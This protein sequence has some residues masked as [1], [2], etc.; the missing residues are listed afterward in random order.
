MKR[1]T[2]LFLAMLSLSLYGAK[3]ET[4][5]AYRSFWP[6]SA[7]MRAFGEAGIDTYAVMPSNSF[8]TLGEPYCKFPPFWVWDETY[9][10]NVV[11]EQFDLVI[12]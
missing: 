8:N 10:W 2:I 5:F 6:E 1:L 7:A 11:D 3:K 4:F 12:H 9:L